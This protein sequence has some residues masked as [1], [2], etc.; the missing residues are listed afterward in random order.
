MDDWV[1]PLARMMWMKF[2]DIPDECERIPTKVHMQLL[3]L[4]RTLTRN[5]ELQLEFGLHALYDESRNRLT[6]STFWERIDEPQR[7]AGM[8]SDVY[9]RA[10]GNAWFSSAVETRRYLSAS[11]PLP[12][13][14]NQLFALCE[15]M[16]LERICRKVRPGTARAFT[17]RHHVYR[18][19]AAQQ[20]ALRTRQGHLAD[21][22]V[23]YLYQQF[24]ATFRY[25]PPEAN[26]PPQLDWAQAHVDALVTDVTSAQATADIAA[27]CQRFL[28]AVSPMLVE[29]VKATYFLTHQHN[30]AQD[31]MDDTETFTDLVRTNQL[32]N[33]IS[34]TP[35]PPDEA[36]RIDESME[37]WHRE[38]ED[39]AGNLLQ[40]NL[41]RGTPSHQ[42]A[43]AW[44][45]GD[46]PAA[47][48]SDVV[49]GASQSAAQHDVAEDAAPSIRRSGSSRSDKNRRVP[50]TS[51]QH[52]FLPRVQP[53]K[54][55]FTA[56]GGMVD[57]V[58]SWTLRLKHLIEAELQPKQTGR[59]EGLLA[60]RLST[61]LVRAVIDPTP[62]MFRK[63]QSP[64]H[65]WDAA[66]VLLVDCS[67]SMFD[68]M[69]DTRLGV[70][71]F[72]ET[73][74]ALRVVH[75]VV[76]FWEDTVGVQSD[77]SLTL[78]QPVIEFEECLKPSV[79][80]AICQLESH[81]DNRDGYAIRVMA[82]KL[83]RRPERRKFLIVF[84]D[85][86]PAALNYENNGVYDTHQAVLEARRQ[87]IQV[88]NLFLTG[89]R[90]TANTEKAIRDIYGPGAVTVTDVEQLAD[91]FAPVL[92]RL[93][94]SVV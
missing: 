47:A 31:A 66:F 54:T 87:G 53:S 94:S 85:G 50:K 25:V 34:E 18:A 36:N 24:V 59:R 42:R 22:L 79:G 83:A 84:S 40:M 30:A 82:K 28:A 64:I 58:A 12:S 60:G 71:L 63:K 2:F 8:K 90:G 16:R 15:D 78:F 7:L 73:L 72:H 4:A 92:R 10:I 93:L 62:R 37:I 29:D 35:A 9:L 56:Y 61:K 5:P 48:L 68:R 88:V 27:A 13:L 75:S 23:L 67:G 55:E 65:E 57:Q 33:D 74:K 1:N 41:E 45:E 6:V 39:E 3:D 20:Q 38:T 46:D 43:E 32:D 86:E 21:V 44:R 14:A 17:T 91:A 11:R 19:F 49:Q 52:R 69:E 26:L 51:V 80:P 70:T 89:G 81:L 77:A 76:G